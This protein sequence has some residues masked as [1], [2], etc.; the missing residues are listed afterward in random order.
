MTHLDVQ[1]VDPDPG[2]G[3]SQMVK[4]DLLEVYWLRP[5]TAVTSVLGHD[6]ARSREERPYHKD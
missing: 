3:K 6:P 1:G 5:V 2:S 4:F